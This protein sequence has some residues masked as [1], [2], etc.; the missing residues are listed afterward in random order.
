MFGCGNVGKWNRADEISIHLHLVMYKPSS[1]QHQ[2]KNRAQP[3]L[4]NLIQSEKNV[5]FLFHCFSFWFKLIA[6]IPLWPWHFLLHENLI[7]YRNKLC[8]GFWNKFGINF[9]RKCVCVC[10]ACLN[11]K[12]KNKIRENGKIVDKTSLC[13]FTVKFTKNKRPNNEQ[14]KGIFLFALRFE[15][16]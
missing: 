8:L 5:C 1:E 15:I 7:Y 3:K 11:S 9:E 4:W 13:L 12:A 10:A 14:Q 16:I 6:L 2:K